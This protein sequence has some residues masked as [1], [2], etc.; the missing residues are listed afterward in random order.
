MYHKL[1]LTWD[2]PLAAMCLRMFSR[3]LPS[4]P[5]SILDINSSTGRQLNALYPICSDCVGVDYRPLMISY[6]QSKYPQL[7]FHLGDMHSFRLQRSF[8]VILCLRWALSHALTDEDV[9]KILQTCADHAQPGTLVI[10][11]IL[12]AAGYIPEREFKQ[13]RELKSGKGHI[14]YKFQRTENFLVGQRLWQVSGQ[15][16]IEDYS[17]YRLFS[18]I[19]IQNLL[20]TKGFQVIGMFDNPDLAESPLCGTELCV[21]A[22]F[23]GQ[24]SINSVA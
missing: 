12:N 7:Q 21:A 8:E 14:E 22:I 11:E 3:Y 23:I 20:F 18:P 19:D 13:T 6:A 2:E 16:V 4:H 9:D 15:N 24:P 1:A 5:T 10:L 17:K